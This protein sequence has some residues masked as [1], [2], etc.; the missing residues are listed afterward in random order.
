MIRED[1][2]E[3]IIAYSL[4]HTYREYQANKHIAFD[5]LFRIFR[6]KR[7]WLFA[8]WVGLDLDSRVRFR[9]ATLAIG[10]GDAEK[11]REVGVTFNNSFVSFF[12]ET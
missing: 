9:L 3:A 2:G 12:P 7:T 10:Q 1:E 4:R 6:E 5:Q 8:N 11:E